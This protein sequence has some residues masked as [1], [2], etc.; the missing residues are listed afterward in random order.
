MAGE[1]PRALGGVLAGGGWFE[2]MMVERGTRAEDRSCCRWAAEAAIQ[3][4]GYNQSH[5]IT[6]SAGD[7]KPP[8]LRSIRMKWS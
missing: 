4:E 7:P 1:P 2:E 5:V 8:R 3:T 6:N